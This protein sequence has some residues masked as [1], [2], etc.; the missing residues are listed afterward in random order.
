MAKHKAYIGIKNASESKTLE[1]HFTDYIYDG[2]DWDTW[3]TI[4]LVQDTINKIRDA[5]PDK[6]K[7]VINS[8]GGDVMIGLALYNYLKAHKAEKEVEIIGFAASIAS[9]MAMCADKGKLKMAKN[10]F[11]IIHAAWSYAV[12]TASEMREQAEQLDKVTNELADIYAQRSGKKASHFTNLWAGG[13][14]WLTG[15]EALEEGLADELFNAD[16]VKA[17]VDISTYDFK[18]I[19]PALLNAAKPEEDHKSFFTNLKSEFMNIIDSLKAAIS[20]AKTDKKYDKVPE[21]DAV[22]DMMNEIIAKAEAD[23]D[24]PE[25]K[26]A[27]QATAAEQKPAATEPATAQPAAQ[28]KPA[29][30]EVKPAAEKKEEGAADDASEIKRLNDEI[31]K[32]QAQ[33]EKLKDKV[34][35]SQTEPENDG[36][37]S[38]NSLSRVKVEYETE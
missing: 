32:L 35:A 15:E 34:A 17:H 8:L 4:N 11:M 7:V 26:P 10:S 16:P 38:K 13:D 30:E 24:K 36:T 23:A 2:F 25:E 5:N 29:A 1:L 20:G 27:A 14:V 19:P 21:R 22:L 6:I 9:V 12:G 37:A 28:V 33:A 18:N 3:E 31:Q